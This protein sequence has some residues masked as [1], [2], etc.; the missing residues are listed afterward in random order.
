MRALDTKLVNDLW[1]LR[2][3]VLAIAV[4]LAAAA[5]IYVLSAG[6]HAS[7]TRTSTLYYEQAGFADVFAEMT[8]APADIVDRAAAIPRVA[9]AEGG[10]R[11]LATIDLAGSDAPMRAIVN[12]IDDQR[13]RWINRITLRSGRMPLPDMPDEVVADEAFAEA[14]GLE[15]GDSIVA[16]IYGKREELHIVVIGLAPDHI[17]TIAPG[18]LVPDSTRFGVLWMGRRALEAA[19]D[20]VGAVNAL[21]LLL[22]PDAVTGETIR[23]LDQLL[24][25]YGGTGA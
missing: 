15:P 18:E 3:Q 19:T 13:A 23:Q 9:R 17:F 14:N 10:I 22:E 8:R 20:R 1:R 24:K 2:G 21:A 6:T 16:V 12:S 5:V 7:L 4:V 25:P 11:Q